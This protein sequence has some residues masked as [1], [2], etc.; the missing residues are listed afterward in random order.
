M[1]YRN[2]NNTDSHKQ[3][4]RCEEVKL[5]EQ[6]PKKKAAHDGLSPYCRS[7]VAKYAA[8]NKERIVEYVNK[9]VSTKRAIAR[10]MGMVSE[11]ARYKKKSTRAIDRWL[12]ECAL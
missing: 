9:S 11:I 2:P 1:K 6:F 4:P 5:R 8:A 12:D 3:C 7:C 10:E